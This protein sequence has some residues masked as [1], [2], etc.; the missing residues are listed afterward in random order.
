MFFILSKVLYFLLSPFTWI[1]ILLIFS[2]VLN[3]AK[4]KKLFFVS[5]ICCLF[6]FSNSFIVLEITRLW[7]IPSL[8]IDSVKKHDIGIILGGMAEFDR[9]SKRLS[10][11]RGGDRIWQGLNLYYAKKINKVLISGD[12][13]Y[14]TDKGLHEADQFKKNL[15]LF[16]FPKDDLLIETNSR[17]TYE[18]AVETFNVLKKNKFLNKKTILVTSGLHMRRARATFLKAGINCSVFSTDNYTQTPRSYTIGQFLIPNV[19]NF[20]LWHSLLKEIVGYFFYYLMG[21][22]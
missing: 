5:S 19:D 11:R 13:G 18:N 7:E 9:N 22:L 15:L 3:K 21:Y 2:A 12:N 20:N 8:S 6:F 4:L 1:L 10:L 14:I 16:K 17:N